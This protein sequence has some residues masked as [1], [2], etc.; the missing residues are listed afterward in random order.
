[1]SPNF[2]IG[3]DAEVDLKNPCTTN[4]H[5]GCAGIPTFYDRS[6]GNDPIEN[7]QFILG[8]GNNQSIMGWP[9]DTQTGLLVAVAIVAGFLFLKK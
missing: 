5:I 8:G 9:V 6:I 2:N 1:M 3:W 4:W 7:P